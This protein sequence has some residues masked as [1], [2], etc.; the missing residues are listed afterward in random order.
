MEVDRNG[1]IVSGAQ[2][3]CYPTRLMKADSPNQKMIVSGEEN[4]N[5]AIYRFIWK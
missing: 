3:L 1:S 5:I 4:G 2:E